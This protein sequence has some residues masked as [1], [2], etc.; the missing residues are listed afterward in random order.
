MLPSSPVP[1]ST[2]PLLGPAAGVVGAL[3]SMV[4][5]VPLLGLPAASVAT[6][7]TLL[8]SGSGDAGVMLQLPWSSAVV[9]P[10]GLLLPS[11]TVTVLPGSAVPLICVPLPGLT[12]GS[13]GGVL[14]TVTVVVSLRLPEEST[15]TTLRVA[16]SGSG[17]LG[18]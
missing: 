18:V 7:V 9:C 13:A 14:S 11:V 10:T 3:V 15:A 5:V 16:P 8:P 4:S 17:V 6:T 12:S 1:L 2:V